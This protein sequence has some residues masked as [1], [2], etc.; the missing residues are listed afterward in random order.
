MKSI[1]GVLGLVLVLVGTQ[2]QHLSCNP[3]TLGPEDLHQAEGDWVL[4]WL[5]HDKTKRPE[6]DP[7]PNFT[8]SHVEI[9]LWSN[10]SLK[11]HE[12]NVYAG[13]KCAMYTL[14][15][16]LPHNG[17]R[18]QVEG[19]EE[20][21]DGEVKPYNDT[22]EAEFLHSSEN[23]MNFLYHS[24]S[25]GTFLLIYMKEGHHR[26]VEVLQKH[27][28]EHR[29]LAQCLNLSGDNYEEWSYDG[30]ADF[31]HR[32]SAPEEKKEEEKEKTEAS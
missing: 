18:L 4:V 24:N 1:L 7:L 21:K 26:D 2:A 25:H 13:G 6:V 10:H 19:G 31:C 5:V 22:A 9:R 32:T 30:T 11:F 16:T 8:S 3:K 20:H 17:H 28:E 29:K 14:N 12:R 27:Q 15:M 23:T